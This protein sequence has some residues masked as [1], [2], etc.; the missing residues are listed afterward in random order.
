MDYNA[1]VAKRTRLSEEKYWKELWEK[2]AGKRKLRDGSDKKGKSRKGSNVW[3]CV[4]VDDSEENEEV[5]VSLS[6]GGKDKKKGGK[7]KS[8]EG[9]KKQRSGCDDSDEGD[10]PSVEIISESSF[11]KQDNESLGFDS[12]ESAGSNGKKSNSGAVDMENFFPVEVEDSDDE[13]VYLGEEKVGGFGC[14]SSE[15]SDA[16]EDAASDGDTEDAASDASDES[17]KSSSREDSIFHASDESDDEAFEPENSESSVFSESLNSC[18]EEG[19]DDEREVTKRSGKPR[20]GKNVEGDVEVKKGQDIDA[21][22]IAKGSGKAEKGKS[23][24]IG[25]RRKRRVGLDMSVDADD[26]IDSN[27]DDPIH[28]A[29]EFNSVAKRTRSRVS[30]RSE[31]KRI[32]S[33][34]VNDNEDSSSGH[35]NDN[36]DVDDANCSGPRTRCHEKKTGSDDDRRNDESD[37]TYGGSS[38]TERSKWN[39][40]H[41]VCKK[42]KRDIGNLTNRRSMWA[43]EDCNVLKILVDSIYEKGEGTLKGSVSFGDEGRKDERNPPESEM[44]TLPLKFSFGEQSTVPKKSECDPEEKELWDDLEF[45]LRASEIDSSDSNV[46]ESQDSLPIADE[47]ETVASLCRRGVHQLILDEEI[48]LRCKFCSY[49]D[50]E[51]K[52]ILPDF[53]DCP[54]GRFGTRGSETDNRSIFDELQSHASDSDRHSGYNSHPHVDGTVWDLIPGVKSSM[55]PHQCEG[56]EFI[57][58]HIAGGIRLDKLKRPSSV[59]GGNGCIISH[60]PGTGKTR[61]TIVF[62]QTYMKLFPE[63]RPLLIAPRSMLLTWEEEFKKWKLDIPFHNLNNW[64][65]SG[66]ENQTAVNY[67]MQAQ[68]RKSVNIESRRMLKLYSW[69]KKRSILGISYRLFEQLSGAQKTGSVDEMG[70]ILLEFPGLVVFDEGH[71]PR[72]DQSHMWKALSEIKTKRRILLSGTPFQNNFQ[73]LFNTICLVRPTFAA[74]IESTK[75]SRDL[76]RN[77]GRKSNGEKW[78]WTSLA[79]SSGKVVDD[80]EKH[81]T[82]V[83]AQI[84]P[85]VHVY[86]GSVLQDSLPGLR[87]SV[88]VLHPTQLQE[89]F[90]KRI[91]V[92]KELFRYE[93]LEALISFHPSLLLKE[94]AFSADQGRLQELKLN[95]DA[96]V[97]AKF[98][99]ELIRLSDALKEKV[100]VFSQY[101][102]PLNLT[103][104]LLKS[105]FQWTEGEEVLYMDGKSDMKQRQSSMKVFNDPSSKAKVLLASTKA[106]SEG[107]SLV[108]ASRVVLLD[109][110]WNPSVE[111]QAISRAY[112]LGQKKVVFVYHLLMDGT[113]EEHKYSRQVDKSRL[114][115]LVFSDSDKKKVLEKEI[116]ATVSEDKILQEM[117]QHG[118]LKHLFKSIA[119]LHED[120]YFEQLGLSTFG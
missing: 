113:N 70:K 45:A 59:V 5:T 99:M 37:K 24:E 95:P 15:R 14:L 91:Q 120:I 42:N 12:V 107:I 84:A 54:Y 102:D 82:E 74:S 72:N 116:G 94:D 60:A 41:G 111:R 29:Q 51:I 7:R 6:T 56:F 109:V 81:A 40:V 62:L 8:A 68:R 71:T 73:E 100:L 57:W 3:D 85:F 2:R 39:D 9:S 43:K 47:V 30:P 69:R 64:E 32:E 50:Q 117:A 87:N 18:G 13:V 80:K 27:K 22:E 17:W 112:R 92:V 48:G 66:K 55:Y 83:K 79:S 65:L 77:R 97:K 110:T 1:P 23:V 58:N 28:S 53:L 93:N 36:E 25:V 38:E 96:G 89:R 4:S 34:T 20:K 114:S 104:D 75:F 115:E 63:C 76:P 118:K 67:V 105:Q 44:T 33:V 16:C 49:L 88:V 78:K 10:D 19:H 46:V 103:R 106:C 98:V 21:S 26:D 35:D 101:I 31:N 52:Y 86:K 119:L 90:H 11:G 61:L 108:G